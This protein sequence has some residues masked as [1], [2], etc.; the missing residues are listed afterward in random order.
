MSFSEVL[1][2]VLQ[3]ILDQSDPNAYTTTTRDKRNLVSVV[4]ESQDDTV[5]LCFY[6]QGTKSLFFV[7]L[8]ELKNWDPKKRKQD[9]RV[10]GVSV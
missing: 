5:D 9:D 8:Q 10:L 7:D 2:D 1:N 3:E 4:K 6:N